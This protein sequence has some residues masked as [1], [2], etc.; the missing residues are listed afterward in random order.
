MT[1]N[2]IENP[3]PDEKVCFNCENM[4]WMVAL[5]LGLKCRLDKKNIEHR[6][7]TCEKFEKKVVPQ[8]NSK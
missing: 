2:K 7:H 8:N 3:A 6:F 4:M 1:I 5:G